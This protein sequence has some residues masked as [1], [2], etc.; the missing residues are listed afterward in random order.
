MNLP[1][2]EA[3]LQLFEPE[4]EL[5]YTIEAASR[6]TSIPKHTI[7]VYCR[8]NLVS[9]VVD[10]DRGGWFFDDEAIRRLRHI[11]HLRVEREAN[12]KAISL[13]F[14]LMRQVEDLQRELRFLRGV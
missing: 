11:E 10:P 13:I 9:P 5:V 1:T 3:A 12:L 2:H 8:Y 6:I 4:P 14:D 7:A